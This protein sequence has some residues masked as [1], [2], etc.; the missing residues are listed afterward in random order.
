MQVWPVGLRCT[1]SN[2][3][4][5]DSEKKS[6]AQFSYHLD[7]HTLFSFFFFPF[8]YLINELIFY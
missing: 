2:Y 5:L 8:V 4:M 1:E 7:G 6:G 3:K